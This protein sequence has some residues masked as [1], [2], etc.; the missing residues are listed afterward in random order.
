MPGNI[1]ENTLEHIYK[2]FG[3]YFYIKDWFGGLPSN[4]PV[5][6]IRYDSK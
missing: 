2:H 5:D 3:K 1:N 6:A 4:I